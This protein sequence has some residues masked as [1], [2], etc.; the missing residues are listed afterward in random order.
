ME[1][2]FS[3]HSVYLDTDMLLKREGSG[4]CGF[5]ELAAETALNSAMLPSGTNCLGVSEKQGYLR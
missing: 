2:N 5:G 1:I 4:R 3:V